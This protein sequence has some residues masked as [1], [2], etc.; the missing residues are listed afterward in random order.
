MIRLPLIIEF[1]ATATT[2]DMD[3][4]TKKLTVMMKKGK[5]LEDM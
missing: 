5:I 4:S 2:G 1:Y 3:L